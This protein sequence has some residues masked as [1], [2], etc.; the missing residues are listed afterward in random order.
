MPPRKL[1]PYLSPPAHPKNTLLSAEHQFGKCGSMGKQGDFSLPTSYPK[2]PSQR[3]HGVNPK[4]HFQ[5]SQHRSKRNHSLN[6]PPTICLTVGPLPD[7]LRLALLPCSRP[8]VNKPRKSQCSLWH[9]NFQPQRFILP[10]LLSFS[11]IFIA[12]KIHLKTSPEVSP[13]KPPEQSGLG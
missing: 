6:S 3:H 11:Q 4:T 5:I 10:G 12:K 1:H 7:E 9:M 13:N 2:P 8:G